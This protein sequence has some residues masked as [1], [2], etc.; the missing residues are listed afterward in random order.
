[1]IVKYMAE[2]GI[3]SYEYRFVNKNGFKICYGSFDVKKESL[4]MRFKGN[5]LID[6]EKLI[7]TARHINKADREKLKEDNKDF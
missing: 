3:I 2:S 7:L 5:M 6:G 1:M 4:I